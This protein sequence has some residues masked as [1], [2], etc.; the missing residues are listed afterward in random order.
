M[1]SEY[2]IPNLL[3]IFYTIP[4]TVG[5]ALTNRD[6]KLE[7]NWEKVVISIFSSAIYNQLYNFILKTVKR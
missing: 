6:S 7:I 5:S 3:Y 2:S 1:L 4:I